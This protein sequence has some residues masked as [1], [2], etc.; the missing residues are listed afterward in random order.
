MFTVSKDFDFNCFENWC[1]SDE[2]TYHIG[3]DT[4]SCKMHGNAIHFC[5]SELAKFYDN[6]FC[7]QIL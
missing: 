6:N 2:V 5:L 4:Y 3:T 1:M 7:G